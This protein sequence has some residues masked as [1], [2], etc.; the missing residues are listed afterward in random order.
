[1]TG[2]AVNVT[3]SQGSTALVYAVR[4]GHLTLLNLLLSFQW[5]EA[6]CRI[7]DTAQE[8]LVVAA[9]SGLLLIAETLINKKVAQVD[10]V[11][12]LTV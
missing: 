6:G 3:D 7:Q 11:C 8:S 1:M 10:R 12:S 2:A 5:P 9:K 4:G